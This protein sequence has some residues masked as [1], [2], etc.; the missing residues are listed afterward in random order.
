MSRT[1]HEAPPKKEAVGKHKLTLIIS[2]DLV[3]K[4]RAR[5]VKERRSMNRQAEAILAQALEQHAA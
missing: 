4:L 3:E 1:I 2:P 5:A